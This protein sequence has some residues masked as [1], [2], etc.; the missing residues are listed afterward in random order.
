LHAE[1]V[2]IAAMEVLNLWLEE[3]QIFKA[4]APSH[5][6]KGETIRFWKAMILVM[7]R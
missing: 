3:I 6:V 2:N 4:A 1:N 5:Y 7:D